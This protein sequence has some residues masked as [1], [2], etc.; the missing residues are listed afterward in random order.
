ML[1]LTPST[2]P[3]PGCSA[4]RTM[5]L[6]RPTSGTGLPIFLLHPAEKAQPRTPNA[7]QTQHDH[8][9]MRSRVRVVPRVLLNFI[10][11]ALQPENTIGGRKTFQLCSILSRTNEKSFAHY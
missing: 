3:F 7:S 2:K 10:F 8:C 1:G 5:L 9:Q 6:P 4:G 11:N